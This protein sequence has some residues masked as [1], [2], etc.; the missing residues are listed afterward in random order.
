MGW[1]QRKADE[2]SER[3]TRKYYPLYVSA[4]MAD[5]CPFCG[6]KLKRA[7]GGGG[8]VRYAVCHHCGRD[9]YDAWPSLVRRVFVDA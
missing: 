4:F 8:Q 6:K 3:D 1:L 2:I 5:R 7:P 9:A